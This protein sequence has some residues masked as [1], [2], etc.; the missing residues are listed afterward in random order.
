MESVPKINAKGFRIEKDIRS[1]SACDWC[2]KNVQINFY[3]EENFS[4]KHCYDTWGI[5]R[6]KRERHLSDFLVHV[7]RSLPRY[8]WKYSWAYSQKICS[9]SASD[10]SAVFTL[11]RTNSQRFKTIKYFTRF[12]LRLENL[13]LWSRKIAW[14]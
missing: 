10:W 12:Q 8:L 2:P 13:W 14:I 7:N 4:Q 9:L 11:C 3:S 5:C 6:P 1:F